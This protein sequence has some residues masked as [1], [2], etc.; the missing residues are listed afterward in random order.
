MSNT[1]KWEPIE[2][3]PLKTDVIFLFDGDYVKIEKDAAEFTAPGRC[4]GFGWKGAFYIGFELFGC[5]LDIKVP[6]DNPPIAFARITIP[7]FLTD[8]AA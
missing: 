5:T 1:M 8:E 3:V 4:T 2:D 6:D 7:D